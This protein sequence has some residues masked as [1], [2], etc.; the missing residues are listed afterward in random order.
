[1]L[2][3]VVIIVLCF[4]F[5]LVLYRPAAFDQR[6]ERE[7]TSVQHTGGFPSTVFW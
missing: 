1:M 7:A 5:V 3:V 4:S 2:T 6:W